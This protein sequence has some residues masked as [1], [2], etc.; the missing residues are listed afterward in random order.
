MTASLAARL[1]QNGVIDLDADIRR[2]LPS[3]P[4][5]GV[6]ITL[7]QLL[8][9]LGGIRHYQG[10]DFD[11]TA[12]GGMIDTRPYPDD[13]AI[14]ALF[15]DDLLVSTPG[16]KFNYTTFGYTLV[17]LVLEEATGHDYYD[18][19]KEYVL[20]PS[21]AETVLLDDMYAI[22]PN[23]A[24]FYDLTSSYD[25][26]LPSSL[27]PVVNARPLNS[28]YKRPG[29][30]LIATA[31]DLVKIAAL[32]FEPGF[33]SEDLY[34]QTFTSQK[35]AEGK[36]TGTGLGWRIGEDEAGRTYYHH[37]GSQA[38]CR[39]FLIIYPEEKLALA[40]LSNLANQPGD[41]HER[42]QEIAELFF[43]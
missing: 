8:G 37:R 39:A 32:H 1:A 7:R 43:E 34:D 25:G 2:T 21:A 27:G 16:E 10:K 40:I 18:L 13:N 3:F 28:A 41:I 11:F 20:A 15:A 36:L 33:L 12:P 35:D 29:G 26:F 4:D 22:T 30:G 19:L 38:G 23:R 31:D 17:G 14:L 6:R 42:T 24:E 5:K 9:H